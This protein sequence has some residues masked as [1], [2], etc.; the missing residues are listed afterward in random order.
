MLLL[1]NNFVNIFILKLYLLIL[2]NKKIAKVVYR[3]KNLCYNITY[4]NTFPEINYV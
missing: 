2:L 1:S 4:M 3:N